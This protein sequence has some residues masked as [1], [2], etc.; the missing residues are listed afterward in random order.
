MLK[1]PTFTDRLVSAGVALGVALAFLPLPQADAST[2]KGRG[3][4]VVLER[5]IRNGRALIKVKNPGTKSGKYE[6]VVLDPQG[7]A[8]P[9]AVAKPSSFSLGRGR[10]RRVRLSNVPSDSSLCAEV[11]I[12][13]SLVLRSCAPRSVD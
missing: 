7:E 6:V 9:T 13:S 3:V 4:A 11:V 2:G 8:V 5:E 10:S 12:D 1:Y